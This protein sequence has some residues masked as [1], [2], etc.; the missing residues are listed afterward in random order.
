MFDDTKQTKKNLSRVEITRIELQT[1]MNNQINN[2]KK[3][4]AEQTI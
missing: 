1:P 4:P 2:L 3:H